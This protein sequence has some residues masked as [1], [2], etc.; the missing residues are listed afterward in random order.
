LKQTVFRLFSTVSLLVLALSSAGWTLPGSYKAYE[1]YPNHSARSLSHVVIEVNGTRALVNAGDTFTIVQGDTLRI[2][3]ATMQDREIFPEHVNIVGFSSDRSQPM[4]DRGAAFSTT[5]GFDPEW[6]VDEGKSTYGIA[7]TTKKWLHGVVYMKVVKPLLKFA[8]VLVN[9]KVR[10]MREGEVLI[11]A[12]TDK[13]QV[14]NVVTNL[15]K[16]ADVD[17]EIIK[18]GNAELENAHLRQA[19]AYEIRFSR[20]GQVFA[21]IPMLIEGL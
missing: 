5:K 17:F 3:N 2:I 20:Q 11:L 8:D 7:V 14:Q 15:E 4:E 16:T 19:T 9:D 6:A 12:A 10:V 13:I 21:K 18:T 1:T